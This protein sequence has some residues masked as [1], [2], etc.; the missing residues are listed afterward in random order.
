M[1]TNNKKPAEV[2]AVRPNKVIVS[3]DNLKAFNKPIDEIER[4]LKVGSYLE[5]SDDKNCKLIA[6]IESYKIEVDEKNKINKGSFVDGESNEDSAVEDEAVNKNIFII[7]ANPLGTLIGDKFTRGGNS[8]TIPP[9]GTR[10]ASHADIKKIYKG[11]IK[12]NEK[13]CFSKLAQDKKIKVPVDGNKFF[14]KHFAIV[15][16]TGSGKSHT[17]A[18]VL[19]EAIK[20]KKGEYE[21]LNN[22]HIVLFDIHNEY[23][24]AFPDANHIGIDDLILPYWLLNSEELAEIFLDTEANDHNQRNV[25]KESIVSSK[26]SHFKGE[27]SEREK[28]H[29]DSPLFFE[30]NDV[31]KYANDKNVEMVDGENNK[32]KQ[33]SLFGKLT[34]FVSRLENKINDK[35]LDFLLGEKSKN[36]TFEDTIKQIIGYKKESNIT[37]LD[38]GGIPFEV[39]SI[40]VSLISRLLFDYGYFY[41]KLLD[42]KKEKVE[43]ESEEKI[44]DCDTPILLIYEEAHKYVPK[45][46]LAEYRASKKAIERI[47]KE[48]RKYGVTLGIVSQRPSEI[49][50]TIFSQCNSFVVMRLTNPE[51]QSYVKRL[52]PD[53]LGNLTDILPSLQSGEALL[54]GESIIMPSLVK[55]DRCK[56]KPSSSDIKYLEVWQEEWKK[57]A[58][59]NIINEWKK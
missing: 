18:K 42:K 55:I 39:L 31:L 38:L 17:V 5:V 14:D 49:S 45:S 46:N 7:E 9:T 25:F 16:S 28:I 35:R 6:V 51:D 40:T 27:K 52:L 3:V 23:K 53:T 33:G 30:I 48:G 34:N 47:A 2:I 4:D 41:K 26:K 59:E 56:P 57:V 20:G 37:I 58:F 50:E 1:D 43:K 8:L 10:P 13:F 11:S 32:K 36:I 22:S 12:K 54:I 19:Q 44:N 24:K 29:Y 15:G 21:G